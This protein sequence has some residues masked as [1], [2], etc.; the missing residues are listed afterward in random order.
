MQ[1]GEE[2]ILPGGKKGSVVGKENEFYENYMLI[3]VE[4]L[5]EDGETLTVKIYEE[6]KISEA[7]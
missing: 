3:V 7:K 2:V 1:I 5:A 4:I 6:T